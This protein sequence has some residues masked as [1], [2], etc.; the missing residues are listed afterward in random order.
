MTFNFALGLAFSLLI[1]SVL[2][3]RFSRGLAAV[4]VWRSIV[5]LGFVTYFESRYNFD[6]LAFFSQAAAGRYRDFYPSIVLMERNFP[7]LSDILV[8]ILGFSHSYQALK[9]VFSFVGFMGCILLAQIIAEKSK[10]SFLP[11]L[12]LL[13]L[14]PA[15]GYWTAFFG[16]DP[17]VFCGLQLFLYALWRGDWRI[18]VVGWV[19][20]GFFRPWIGILLAAGFFGSRKGWQRWAGLSVTV[21]GLAFAVWVR[22]RVASVGDFVSLIDNVAHAWNRGTTAGAVPTFTSVWDVVS[23]WPRGMFSALFR[24]LP[25]D[26]LPGLS[27]VFGWESVVLILALGWSLYAFFHIFMEKR[28]RIDSPTYFSVLY[29]AFWTATFAFI[30]SQNLIAGARFRMNMLGFLIFLFFPRAKTKTN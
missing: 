9:I 17:L 3:F 27:V 18:G 4:W 6:S 11:I 1:F 24:P 30:S 15:I 7:W 20:A 21:A 28:V 5:T 25:W 2:Y 23:Y 16:K 12:W 14:I 8:R 10:Y 26:R 22:F 19:L 13:H 29:T